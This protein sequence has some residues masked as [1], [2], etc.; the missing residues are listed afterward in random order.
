MQIA[1]PHVNG[2]AST[3][4]LVEPTFPNIAS[5]SWNDSN[6]AADLTI[7]QRA[8]RQSPEFAAPDFVAQRV[9]AVTWRGM[10]FPPNAAVNL[11]TT[12]NLVQ[13]LAGS[14]TAEQRQWRFSNSYQILLVSGVDKF[15]RLA[16]FVVYQY[17][18]GASDPFDSPLDLA[19]PKSS[20]NQV[21]G[22]QSYALTTE[23]DK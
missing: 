6:A 14:G 19:N 17:P 5:V 10:S 11:Q 20:F 4:T 13:G 16:C 23:P 8:V 1:Q 3:P 15:G 2:S 12:L 22:T 18:G 7:A 21:R 9:L